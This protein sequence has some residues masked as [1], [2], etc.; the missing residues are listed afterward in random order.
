MDSQYAK[1]SFALADKTACAA[2]AGTPV[3]S[4]QAVVTI[5]TEIPFDKRAVLSMF[6][7]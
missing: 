3:I 7:A 2:I 5:A 1:M 4:P 6:V